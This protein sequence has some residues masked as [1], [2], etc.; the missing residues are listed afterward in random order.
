MGFNGFFQRKEK[1]KKVTDLT[2]ERD[3]LQ[4][5]IVSGSVN[6]TQHDVERIAIII[7][8]ELKNFNSNVAYWIA[9]RI[10]C[11]VCNGRIYATQVIGSDDA[12]RWF[13]NISM[14]TNEFV[15]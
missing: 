2:I 11:S 3:S 4:I 14:N 5:R 8:E 6:I 1:R 10:T 12:K 7:E 9:R 13:I 15:D